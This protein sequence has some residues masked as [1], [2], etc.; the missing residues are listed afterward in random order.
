MA[1]DNINLPLY[2]LT[3]DAINPDKTAVLHFLERRSHAEGEYHQ[4]CSVCD[5][6]GGDG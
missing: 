4:F 2:F 1:R 5:T 3:N 6:G